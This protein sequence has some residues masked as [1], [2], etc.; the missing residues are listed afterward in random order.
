MPIVAAIAVPVFIFLLP[1]LWFLTPWMSADERWLVTGLPGLC[2][3]PFSAAMWWIALRR[4]CGRPGGF[5]MPWVVWLLTAGAEIV[6][7]LQ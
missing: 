3:L 6:W 7:R 1:V 2:M 4:L 5:L